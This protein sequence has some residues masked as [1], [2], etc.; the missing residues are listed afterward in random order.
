MSL[1][2]KDNGAGLIFLRD[3]HYSKATKRPQANPATR[4]VEAF[5]QMFH[6]GKTPPPS[7]QKFLT[8]QADI[9]NWADGFRSELTN[10]GR[11]LRCFTRK[12]RLELPLQHMTPVSSR[13]MNLSRMRFLITTKLISIQNYFIL[14]LEVPPLVSC[15]SYVFL[16][17]PSLVC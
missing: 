12:K 14:R 17:N 8:L 5:Q 3:I 10:L 4:T 15:G 13:Q 6:R 16:I 2:K 9:Q 7:Q 1:E 11:L